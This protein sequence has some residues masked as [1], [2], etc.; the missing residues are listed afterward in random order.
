MLTKVSQALPMKLNTSEEKESYH[1]L[2]NHQILIA[3]LIMK[4]SSRVSTSKTKL[5]L[6]IFHSL[7]VALNS[8]EF[9]RLEATWS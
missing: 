2:Q 5:P 6:E 8:W 1:L 9:L 3:L 7:D 4:M